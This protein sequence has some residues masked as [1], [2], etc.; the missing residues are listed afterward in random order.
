MKTNKHVLLLAVLGA[1]AFGLEGL[2]CAQAP[3]KVLGVYDASDGGHSPMSIA[4]KPVLV[5]M[6]T[7][8]NFTLDYTSDKT[9]LNDANLAKYDLLIVMN[10]FPFNLSAPQQ[11]AIQKYVEGGKGFIPVHTTG[12]EGGGWAWF[13]K[14]IMGGVTWQGHHNLRQ[15]TLL[16]E[17]HT[18]AIT[19]NLPAST[20]IKEEW[21]NFNGN[22]RANVRVLAKAGPTGDADYDKTDHPMVW[23]S[24]GFPKAVYISPGHD[25]SDWTNPDFVALFHYAILFASPGSTQLKLKQAYLGAPLDGRAWTRDGVL[26][27]ES[28]AAAD[29][30]GMGVLS[31][32]SGRR[33]EI[34]NAGNASFRIRNVPQGPLFYLPAG[35]AAAIRVSRDP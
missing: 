15:G 32:A 20:S 31:D 16:F 35:H 11:A 10:Q 28:E 6:G 29:L 30:P 8:D 33:L 12:C 27:V 19:K 7:T 22:P 25:A 1:A 13:G 14:Q 9:V 17:D 4:G 21:Y 34:V 5:K 23:C 24:L 3:M 2:P 18:H 26:H